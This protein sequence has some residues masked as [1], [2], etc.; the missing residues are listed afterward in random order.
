MKKLTNRQKEIF[1]FIIK[2][3]KENKNSVSYGEISKKFGFCVGT[4]QG[5]ILA[6]EKKGYIYKNQKGKIIIK[7]EI[8]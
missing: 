3:F 8:K 7:G 2:Y 4:I 6:L 5:H 1:D